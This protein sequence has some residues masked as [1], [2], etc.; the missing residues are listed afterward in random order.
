MDSAPVGSGAYTTGG[1][2]SLKN[3]IQTTNTNDKVAP[4]A[5][6]RAYANKG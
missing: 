2:S 4:K 5:L 3:R 6:D 1:G